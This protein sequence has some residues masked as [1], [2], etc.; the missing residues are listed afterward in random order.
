MSAGRNEKE[1]I[2]R[3]TY[4]LSFYSYHNSLYIYILYMYHNLLY[5]LSSASISAHTA[6]VEEYFCAHSPLVS[7]KKTS[8]KELSLD[9]IHLQTFLY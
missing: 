6:N 1:T 4:I 5:I 8:Y 7:I 2:P 9:V 3:N